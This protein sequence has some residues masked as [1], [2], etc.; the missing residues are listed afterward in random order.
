MSRK[1]RTNRRSLIPHPQTVLEGLAENL[2]EARLLRSLLRLARK[3]VQTGNSRQGTVDRDVELSR[4]ER[5]AHKW[6]KDMATEV[7]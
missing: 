4:P 5:D 1:S 6:E 2:R 3:A 7:E